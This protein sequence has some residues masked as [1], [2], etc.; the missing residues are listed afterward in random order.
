MYNFI[1][2][3]SSLRTINNKFLLLI[4]LYLNM[5]TIHVG[6]ATDQCIEGPD[7]APPVKFQEHIHI[8]TFLVA[9]IQV[10]SG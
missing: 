4:N 2:L 1:R 10:G 3:L 7:L 6:L 5:H 9:C 8:N